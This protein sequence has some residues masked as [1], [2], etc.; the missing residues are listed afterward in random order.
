MEKSRLFLIINILSFYTYWWASLWGAS[1]KQYY[2]GPLIA[3]IYFIFHF[4]II[5]DK[6]KEFQYMLLCAFCGFLLESIFLY[7]QFIVYRGILPEKY[8]IVPIWAIVL[9]AGYALTAYHSFKWIYGK[10]YFSLLIGG[11]FGPLIYLS[12]NKIGC[13]TFKYDVFTSYLILSPIWAVFFLLLTYFA[14]TL[15]ND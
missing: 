6:K 12:G 13:I 2:I 15:N 4:S 14:V 1:I 10:Y 8:S 5:N 7:S 11:I 9:W 3:L